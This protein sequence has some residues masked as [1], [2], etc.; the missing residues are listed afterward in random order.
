MRRV[1]SRDRLRT[2]RDSAGG[3][4]VPLLMPI[5]QALPP[6]MP[7]KPSAIL[8]ANDFVYKGQPRRFL[9]ECRGKNT[10]EPSADNGLRKGV[11]S[12]S[13]QSRCTGWEGASASLVSKLNLWST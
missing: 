2:P 11:L 3:G 12:H 9:T 10:Q 6:L 13:I 8:K 1:F 5:N 7:T 4:G